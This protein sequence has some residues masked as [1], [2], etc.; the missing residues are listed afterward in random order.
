MADFDLKKFDLE[1]WWK[2]L[3]AAGAA[4]LV[5][6]IAV[7]STPTI[8]LGLGLLACG[9][10][11]WIDHPLQTRLGHGFKITGYPRSPSILGV[12]LDCLGAILLIVG[13]IK[14]INV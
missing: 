9:V 8:F 1:H 10:G 3:A 5:A 7:K 14:L 13:L 12:L 11:E 2:L 6:S 4:V